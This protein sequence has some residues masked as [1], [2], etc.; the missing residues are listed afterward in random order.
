M[1]LCEKSAPPTI[2]IFPPYH[3]GMSQILSRLSGQKGTSGLV[4]EIPPILLSLCQP[5]A[6]A[7]GR[8]CTARIFPSGLLRG[9]LGAERLP[10]IA[11]P[12]QPQTFHLLEAQPRMS[13]G[14][15]QVMG[16]L[17]Q[18]LSPLSGEARGGIRGR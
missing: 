6:R 9:R 3:Q 17:S 15:G 1:V 11:Q 2:L 12:E 7:A 4:K 5:L 16:E 14:P 8:S 18:V 10:L 13:G